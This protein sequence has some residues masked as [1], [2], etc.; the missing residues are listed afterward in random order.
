[1][2]IEAGCPTRACT[3]GI[4]CSYPSIFIP[5]QAGACVGTQ[6]SGHQGY[7]GHSPDTGEGARPWSCHWELQKKR[8]LPL[9]LWVSFPDSWR[10]PGAPKIRDIG[11]TW[12]TRRPTA[13][14]S[15]CH[16]HRGPG[17][18]TRSLPSGITRSSPIHCRVTLSR[19]SCEVPAEPNRVKDLNDSAL[20]VI[21]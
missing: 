2:I 11:V 20:E 6:E 12:A 7:L 19:Y 5:R 18:F 14:G 4:L 13:P 15:L 3:C 8:A 16:R 1:V 17:T 9:R 10:L 21:R